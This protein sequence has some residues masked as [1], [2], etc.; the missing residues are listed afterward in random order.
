MKINNEDYWIVGGLGVVTADL[1][2]GNDLVGVLRHNANFG[3]RTCKVSKKEST[4]LDHD[5]LLYGR[6]HYITDKKFLE[7]QRTETRN[8]K[9]VLARSYGLCLER[10]ILDKIFRNRHAQTLQDPF[11]MIAG[12]GGH[13]LNSTFDI[14][15]REGLDAFI[16]T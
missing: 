5:N 9:I 11:H 15:L 6:Y 12:L 2:Q 14:L 1:P 4:Y 7:I 3:C 13:L 8:A 16:V 10:N